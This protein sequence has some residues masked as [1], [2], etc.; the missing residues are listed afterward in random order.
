MR[1]GKINRSTLD[2]KILIA[3]YESRS[4][5]CTYFCKQ[6]KVSKGHLYKWRLHFL[7]HKELVKEE[8]SFIP[9]VINKEHESDQKNLTNITSAIKIISSSGVVVEFIAGC[10][11]LEI[12]AIM[13]IFD[14]AK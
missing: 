5:S 2:W 3:E 10:R 14:A 11:Y 9:L 6:H 8:S 12:K 4:V 13:E 7:S 1:T